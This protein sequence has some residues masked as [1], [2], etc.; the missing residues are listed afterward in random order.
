MLSLSSL[1]ACKHVPYDHAHRKDEACLLSKTQGNLIL[2]MI[3]D[4]FSSGNNTGI[5]KYSLSEREREWGCQFE[6]RYW[7]YC[8]QLECPLGKLLNPSR[9]LDTSVCVQIALVTRPYSGSVIPDGG[10]HRERTSI[11][12]S[13]GFNN[14]HKASSLFICGTYQ[15]WAF[16]LW[17]WWIG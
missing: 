6:Y 2:R 1:L 12:Q 3:L 15:V 14:R 7:F 17:S 9:S 11:N 10:W 4:T 16:R 5:Q 13:L 8:S